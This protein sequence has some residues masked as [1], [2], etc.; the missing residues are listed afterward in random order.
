M[1]VIEVEYIRIHGGWFG[2]GGMPTDTSVAAASVSKYSLPTEPIP[3]AQG[4]LD[5]VAKQP[6]LAGLAGYL[7]SYHNDSGCSK[8]QNNLKSWKKQS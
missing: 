5:S 8:R 1:Q 2:Y 3:T 6:S 7:K 4:G